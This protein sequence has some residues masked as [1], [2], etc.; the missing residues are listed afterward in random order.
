MFPHWFGQ[1][2][3]LTYLNNLSYYINEAPETE[4]YVYIKLTYTGIYSN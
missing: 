2:N 3:F 4:T 1:I